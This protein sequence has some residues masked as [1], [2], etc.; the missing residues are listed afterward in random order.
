LPVAE[1]INDS[2]ANAVDNSETNSTKKIEKEITIT[3]IN[4]NRK[5]QNQNYMFLFR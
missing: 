2:N 5:I 3:S 1:E 4:K